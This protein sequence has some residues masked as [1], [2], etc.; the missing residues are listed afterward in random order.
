MYR[1]MEGRKEGG[2]IKEREKQIVL[3][4]K[5]KGERMDRIRD[6]QKHASL[7]SL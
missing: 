6:L 4:P 2:W 7:S 1:R 5:R 3:A